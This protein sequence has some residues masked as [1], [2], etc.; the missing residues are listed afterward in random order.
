MEKKNICKIC[1]TELS[2]VSCDPI[3]PQCAINFDEDL[4]RFYEQEM[5]SEIFSE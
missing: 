2:F 4:E 1:G 3:C 5:Y